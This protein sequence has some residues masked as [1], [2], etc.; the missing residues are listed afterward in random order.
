MDVG[1][2]GL[3][4]M[5][6]AIALNLVKAGHRVA[7]Y[8]RTRARAE[9]LASEGA[10]IADSVADAARRPVV[11]TMLADDHAV[12]E[13]FFGEGKG[14]SALGAGAVHISMST[15]SVALSER[16]VEAH[17]KAGHAYVAA[18]VFG[19]PEAA[20][21]AKLFVV[22]AGPQETLTRCQPLFDAI[23]QRTFVIGDKPPAANLV[24]LSG[25]FLI[26]AMIESLGEA[27]ALVRKGGV[28]PH[29]YV[30]ILTNTLFS[31]PAYKTYGTI[32]ANEQ[33]EPAGFKMTL[34]LKDIRLAL[35]AADTLAAPMPVAS[36]VH[37][38]FLA[39][40]AQGAGES[41]WAGLA[42]LA[43]QNAGL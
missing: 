10:E 25:N 23:G 41:D 42:R 28:D 1:F 31:A 36:L 27:V 18:P 11:I 2:I 3:G 29:R 13:V 21:A 38:H 9:A 39:G 30:E 5:G 17:R 7:A 33:Y 14:L 40:V 35:A 8:N 22:A 4:Q 34:G 43:A 32:I 12:E 37:D 26:A 20:A 6:R 16:L 19:R 24:K 15:I